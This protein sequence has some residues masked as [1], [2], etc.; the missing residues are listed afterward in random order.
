MA[1]TNLSRS[2]RSKSAAII[3]SRLK[4]YRLPRRP[5]P[6]VVSFAVLLE[7]FRRRGIRIVG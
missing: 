4:S 2:P 3:I 5:L 7:T 6:K 1:R